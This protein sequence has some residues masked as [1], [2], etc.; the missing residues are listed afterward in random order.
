MSF[1]YIKPEKKQIIADEFKLIL[2]FFLITLGIL[3]FTFGF[4]ILRTYSFK[5]ET[6]VMKRAESKII[7]N[8]SILNKK[9]DL[10]HF[11]VSKIQN[12]RAHNIVLQDSIKNLFD[13]IPDRIILSEVNI[14]KDSLVLYGKTPNKNIYNFMLQ[15]PL[16]SIFD[17][18]TTSFYQLPNG[19]LRFVSKNFLSGDKR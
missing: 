8:V 2:I 16:R 17:K 12:I 7:S 14:T 18:T 3:F 11:E 5:N 1:S 15:A 9:I 19:Y 4:L 6:L 13:L 10:I